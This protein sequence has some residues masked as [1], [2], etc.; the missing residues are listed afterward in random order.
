M[1]C[2]GRCSELRHVHPKIVQPVCC[3]G[4]DSITAKEPQVA[5]RIDPFTR[6]KSGAGNVARK[7]CSLGAVHTILI[8]QLGAGHPRPFPVA[9]LPQIVE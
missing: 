4:R 2:G 6:F 9:V 7:K 1:E 5:V 8:D 3:S